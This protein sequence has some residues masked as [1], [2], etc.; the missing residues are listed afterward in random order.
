ML[1]DDSGHG[2]IPAYQALDG[3]TLPSEYRGLYSDEILAT[4]AWIGELVARFDAAS[5]GRDAVVL[6]TSDH[7]ENMG[8][9]GFWFVHSFS[10]MPELAHVPFILRA[11]GL[12]PERRPEPVSHVDILPTLLDLAGLA[13]EPDAA[14]IALA[15]YLRADTP[16]PERRVYCDIGRELSAY[17]ERDFVRVSEIA[18]T[19]PGEAA[20]VSEPTWELFSWSNE[21]PISRV[22]PE[23][24]AKDSIRSYIAATTPMLRNPSEL[25]AHDVEALRALG[26]TDTEPD[27]AP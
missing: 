21:G 17:G 22:D 6:L 3:R 16:L 8:E 23:A 9:H 18:G 27:P 26:Y 20:S 7:G 12:R 1:S 19:W 2:G 4:D 13:P 24:I 25:Q 10:S 5:G 15:P 11:P 14:G